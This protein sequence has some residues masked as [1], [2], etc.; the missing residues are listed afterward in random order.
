MIYV[1]ITTTPERIKQDAIQNCIERNRMVVFKQ[2]IAGDDIE[3]KL[4]MDNDMQ[5]IS[6][7]KN[8]CLSL[9][10][11]LKDEDHVFMLDDDCYLLISFFEFWK[12]HFGKMHHAALTYTHYVTGKSS[13]HYLKKTVSNIDHYSGVNGFCLYFSGYCI[14][15][16]GGYGIGYGKW[17]H[18]HVGLSHRIY[19]AGISQGLFIAPTNAMNHIVSLDRL[20]EVK[21]TY[22]QKERK[23]EIDRGIEY[24]REEQ[25]SADW[26]PYAKKD[27]VLT[28]YYTKTKDEQRAK[29]WSANLIEKESKRLIDSAPC[30][31]VIFT[32]N[33]PNK[34]NWKAL[35]YKYVH[36]KARKG[37]STYNYRF[38]Q[39]YAWLKKNIEY[40]NI[41]YLLD[42]NDTHFIQVPKVE[43]GK[44]YINTEGQ[45][46]NIE[47][48]IAESNRANILNPYINDRGKDI[49]NC[50]VI[51]GYAEDVLKL[52]ESMQHF[53]N[54]EKMCDMSALN[55]VCNDPTVNFEP[56]AVKSGFKSN[57]KQNVFISHK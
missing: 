56:V 55:Y 47:W 10:P 40:C 4:V 38:I 50:G 36:S 22:N 29:Q 20:Q 45:K 52:L 34:V 15:R 6:R 30:D 32:D 11:D 21:S 28:C 3:L 41:V 5:G 48:L 35:K 1:L 9:L 49:W 27:Y 13:G 24:F 54:K 2:K 33:E 31:V 44:V 12:K 37:I 18:E 19:N 8:R 42:I 46:G 57:D 17:G 25:K 26:K 39:Y 23:I 16:I 51:Y 43:R 53:L 7:N 14:N